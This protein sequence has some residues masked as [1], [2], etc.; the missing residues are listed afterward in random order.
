MTESDADELMQH[1]KYLWNSELW[2]VVVNVQ[3]RF[4]DGYE[5]SDMDSLRL[6]FRR[7]SHDPIERKR[8]RQVGSLWIET[9]NCGLRLEQADKIVV[10]CGDPAEKVLSQ[11]KQLVGRTLAR[12][13][14]APPGGD[15]SFIFTDG[16]ALRCFTATGHCGTVWRI[17]SDNGDE[18]HL[19]PGARWSYR[20]GLR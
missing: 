4:E 1:C 3:H 7:P 18:L 13:D 5:P 9:S 20:V 2:R 11:F 14:I 8:H 12:I 15:T 16:A 6:D 10:G 17:S 19:G